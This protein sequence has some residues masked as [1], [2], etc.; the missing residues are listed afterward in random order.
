MEKFNNN[1]VYNAIQTPDGT[2]LQSKHRND[3]VDYTD[4]NG[5]YYS[6]DGGLDYLKRSYD[7]D[8]FTELSK[9]FKDCTL[10]DCTKY[11]NWGQN[12]DKDMNKL[13]KTIFK[14]ICELTTDHIEAIING[15]YCS[16]EMYLYVFNYELNKRN[17]K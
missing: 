6:V 15:N 10:D 14:P 4:K 9:T 7:K 16:N 2:I 17:E 3:Y 1:I 5:Q 12:Y 13:P 8:D 11:L